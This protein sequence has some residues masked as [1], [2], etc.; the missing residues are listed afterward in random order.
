MRIVVHGV[1]AVGGVIAGALARAGH[2]CI[3]IARG[4]RLDAIRENGLHLRSPERSDR[5]P[6]ACV[7]APD[8]IDWRPDDAILLAVKGQHTEAALAALRDAG[9]REQPIFCAQNGVAN[10][11]AALRYFPNVHGIT[12]ML[13]AEYAAPDEAV[14]FASPNF[15]IFEIGRYPSGL[16]P[17][18]EALA[19]ALTPA[20]IVGFPVPNVMESKYGKLIQNLGNIVE[21]ALGR[22]VEA[23]EFV[24]ALRAEARAVLDAAGIAWRDVG[25]SDPRRALM[26]VGTVAGALR[27]GGSSTQSLSRGAGSIETDYLNGEIVLI[28]RLTGTPAPL[29][30]AAT[31][32]AHRLAHARAEPGSMTPDAFAAA[33]GL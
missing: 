29:N 14:G 20:G 32:L 22:G 16:S 21:A 17:E 27:I 1:G 7:G 12:V 9:V 4:A 13:P 5:V 11:R 28:G 25:A 24:A 30:A 23:G 8:A 3:G 33:L 10:E 19:A 31:A 18:A 6:L 15:G 26:R 2:D